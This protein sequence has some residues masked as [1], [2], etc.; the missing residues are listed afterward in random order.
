[1]LRVG[2]G[3]RPSHHHGRSVHVDTS[4]DARKPAGSAG[5]KSGR[6]L[7]I[8]MIAIFDVA[9]PP[10]AYST[11]RSAG[12]SAA[13]G[14]LLSGGVPVLGVAI[15]AVRDRR[16]DVVG[17]LVLAGIVVGTVLGLAFHSARLLLV[18]GSVPTA[19]FG[20]VCLG[21]LWAR[22]P[23]LFSVVLEFTWPD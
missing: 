6:L 1:M 16:L 12:R 4:A 20:F 5:T 21:S 15:V 7:S 14:F 3:H 22:R 8:A 11:L 18:E 23:L 10:A 13:A 17:G 2:R 9:A 19:V